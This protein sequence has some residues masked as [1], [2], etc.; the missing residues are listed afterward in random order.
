MSK[1]IPDNYQQLRTIAKAEGITSTKK[2]D[3]QAELANRG[4]VYDLVSLLKQETRK[5]FD[6][7]K[8]WFRGGLWIH[9]YLDDADRIQIRITDGKTGPAVHRQPL[10]EET[11]REVMQ[12]LTAGDREALAAGGIITKK[13]RVFAA[14]ENAQKANA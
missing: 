14:I 5:L 10:D 8:Q 2:A 11:A 6:Q 3:I 7:F 4:W 13:S 1:T 9:I 12:A